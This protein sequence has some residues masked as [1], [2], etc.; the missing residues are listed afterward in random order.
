MSL[1]VDVI[2]WVS[3]PNAFGMSQFGDGGIAGTKPYCASG[4]Y[5]HRM[6][7]YCSSCRYDPARADGPNAC[8]F[9]V[10][11]WDFL[12]RHADTLRHTAR[13]RY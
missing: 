13:M 9:T 4:N 8:P 7:N 6:S 11:Y 3:L 10:L 5:I 2:D 12:A 1:F